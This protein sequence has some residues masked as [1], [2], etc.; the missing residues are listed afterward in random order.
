MM[1]DTSTW[2][3]IAISSLFLVWF[4][5][6]S[7]SNRKI[8]KKYYSWLE[9]GLSLFQGNVQG[10]VL[11]FPV[12]GGRFTFTEGRN[13]LEK[14]EVIFIIASRENLPLYFT[15]R[16]QGI[17]DEMVLRAT[18]KDRPGFEMEIGLSKDR[19]FK[20]ILSRDPKN[21]YHIIENQDGIT[22][23]W[24]GDKNVAIYERLIDFQKRFS[25]FF[26]RASIRKEEPNVVLRLKM[27][28]S[29]T[30]SSE[31]IFKEF[32]DATT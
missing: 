11:G 18:L 6:G 26:I 9:S 27:E 10:K 28:I 21:P 32:L 23:A 19:R 14:G 3:I 30:Y 24:R 25:L 20:S 17:H 1:M 5:V 7:I 2:I 31:L 12:S 29:K 22:I 8:G 13:K 15:N 16:L 4:V